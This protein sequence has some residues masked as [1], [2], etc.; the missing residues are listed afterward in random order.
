[1]LIREEYIEALLAV[2]EY[3]GGGEAGILTN[4]NKMDIDDPDVL[5]LLS[6]LFSNSSLQKPTT[7][8]GFILLGHPGIGKKKSLWLTSLLICIQ[9]KLFGY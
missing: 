5:T 6:E 2:I 8:S 9:G 4:P 7:R 3:Y 1:M